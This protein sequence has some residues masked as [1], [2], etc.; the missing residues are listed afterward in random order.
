VG[1]IMKNYQIVYD[2]AILNSFI[3]FLPELNSGEV[4]YGCLFSRNKYSQEK[5][6]QNFQLGKIVA[7]DKKDL[8]KKIKRLEVPLEGYENISEENLVL[9]MDV[10]P[11]SL[12]K[13]NKNILVELANRFSRG[14]ID[15]NPISLV[16]TEIHRAISRK[17]VIDF[18]FDNKEPSGLD[19]VINQILINK[20][21]YR[22]I[23][24]REGFHLLVLLEYVDKFPRNWYRSIT[25]LPGCD[26]KNA[27]L[28]PVPGCYQ[29]GYIP[30]FYH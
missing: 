16:S 6:Q 28:T 30:Y 12:V 27:S 5:E 7:K 26:V 17:V 3:K 15:F 9:Y 19:N 14:Q 10:N 29:G 18:D 11:H 20:E 24:T 1:E 2:E 22:I 21:Y 4:Y 13:A 25:A 23:K 8:F